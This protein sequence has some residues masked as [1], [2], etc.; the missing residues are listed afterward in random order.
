LQFVPPEELVKLT[1]LSGKA[2]F[3][4]ERE[5]LKHKVL[6]LEEGDGAER[7]HLRHTQPDQRR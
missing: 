3:Y 6:S 4:K 7:G 1:S 5:A 2:L